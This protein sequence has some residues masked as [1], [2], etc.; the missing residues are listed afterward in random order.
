MSPNS[1]IR[2]ISNR[3]SRAVRLVCWLREKLRAEREQTRLLWSEV[4][5][6]RALLIEERFIKQQR[7]ELLCERE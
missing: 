4:R 6:L 1:I 5:R 7:E 2:E 3:E